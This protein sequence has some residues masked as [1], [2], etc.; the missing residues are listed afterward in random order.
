MS[1]G[2]GD[3]QGRDMA[4]DDADEVPKLPPDA[5]LESLDQRLDRLQRAGAERATRAKG[6]AGS[7]A[8]RLVV[9]QLIGGPV[10]GAIVGW[11]LD[12][13]LGTAPWLM[14][15]LMFVGFAGGF[16]NVIRISNQPRGNAP[17]GQ[18]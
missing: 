5:R 1:F 10:G 4:E 17:D 14:L 9:N 8:G 12:R 6:E 2:G 18:E 16:I 13:W 7:R 15:V 11:L 3:A